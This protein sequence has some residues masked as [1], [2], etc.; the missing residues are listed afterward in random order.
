MIETL[1]TLKNRLKKHIQMLKGRHKYNNDVR[2]YNAIQK[3]SGDTSFPFEQKNAFP[4][5]LDVFKE[6]G[7]I[8]PH[9]FLQDLE[10]ARAVINAAPA[11]HYDIGSRLDGFISHLLCSNA[12]ERVFMIDIRPF[13]VEGTGLLFRQA[14]AT[15]LD[16]I[17]DNSIMSM[18]SLHAV[19]H[20]GLGRYGDPV[21]PK[22]WRKALGSMQ[23]K[24][25][26]GGLLYLSVPVGPKDK[27]C[28]N[29]HRIFDPLTIVDVLDKCDLI[30]FKYIHDMKIYA[31]SKTDLAGVSSLV[32]EYDCGLFIFKK[33]PIV[34]ATSVH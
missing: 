34:Q 6:A 7:N 26:Y 8:D 31:V 4:V 9:Y 32:S 33:K 23:K 10:M 17:E 13:S 28:F 27:L 20:F 5:Y 3:K 25:C 29:A 15:S 12:I 1:R 30:S 21:D 19:E 24:L 11:E 22:A 14:D 16:G 2:L 18:S